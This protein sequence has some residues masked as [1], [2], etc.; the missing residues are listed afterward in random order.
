VIELEVA[1][2]TVFALL[3]GTVTWWS[4]KQRLQAEKQAATSAELAGLGR[5]VRGIAHDLSN[6]LSSLE[7]NLRSAIES[8]EL[9][10]EMLED[11]ERATSAAKSLVD[12]IRHKPRDA[13]KPASVEGIA[14]L[15][16]SLLKR[17]YPEIYVVAEGELFYLGTDGDALQVV[18]NLVLNA[19]REATAVGKGSVQI[20]IVDGGLRITNRV[21]SPSQLDGR[22]YDERVSHSGSSGLGLGIARAAA[23]RIGWTLRHEVNGDRVTFVVE[24][25]PSVEAHALH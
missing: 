25:A 14:R 13:T 10:P 9:E 20:R 6:L 7:P 16:A 4:W 17:Q 23:A 5:E 3:L 22:I 8:H 18:Q 1:L 21:R 15:V 11:V 19:V 24:T 2:F 12:V